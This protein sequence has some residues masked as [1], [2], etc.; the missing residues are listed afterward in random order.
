MFVP[1][2]GMPLGS[3]LKTRWIAGLIS[4]MTMRFR[5]PA[6]FRRAPSPIVRRSQLLHLHVEGHETA[7]VSHGISLAQL[8]Q[9][10][11]HLRFVFSQR[12]FARVCSFAVRP[13][14][15]LREGTAVSKLDHEALCWLRA[16]LQ[17]PEDF[18][19]DSFGSGREHDEEVVVLY[20]FLSRT[21]LCF[22]L[23]F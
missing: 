7:S 12:L 13:I 19:H 6:N 15:D 20:L 17:A 2:A 10:V 21:K 3:F 16:S 1:E 18:E 22:G 11:R 8:V 4:V 23:R 9:D 5:A 14:A